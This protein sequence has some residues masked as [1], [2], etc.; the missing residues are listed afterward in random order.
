VRVL[1]KVLGN[2]DS[3][4]TLTRAARKDNKELTSTAQLALSR[5]NVWTGEIINT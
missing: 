1:Q 2:K 5:G 4:G 3:V